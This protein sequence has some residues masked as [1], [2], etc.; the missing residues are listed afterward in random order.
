MRLN[1]TFKIFQRQDYLY[2]ELLKLEAIFPNV[3]LARERLATIWGG[4]SLLQAYFSIM[5]TLLAMTNWTW[6]YYLNL[7]ETHYPLK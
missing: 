4:A 2:R 3:R 1:R 6:D 7:S 5:K